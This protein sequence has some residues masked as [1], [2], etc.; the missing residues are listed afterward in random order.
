MRRWFATPLWQRILL[1]ILL[2]ALAGWLLGERAAQIKWIGDLFIRLIR[3]MVVPLVLAMI[4]TGVAALGDPRRLGT[5]GG[6]TIGLLIAMTALAVCVGL[7]LGTWLQP[8]AGVQLGAV[9]AGTPAVARPIAEQLLAIVPVNPFAAIA[10][11][12]MFSIIF[13]AMAISDLF[14]VHAVMPARMHCFILSLSSQHSLPS[15]FPVSLLHWPFALM[16]HMRSPRHF[17]IASRWAS[18]IR[19]FL[20]A[21]AEGLAGVLAAC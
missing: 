12:G 8:G 14:S 7:G 11:G 5:M 16:V 9:G 10:G 20:F 3:M 15:G 2:G 1:A 4:I 21:P 18:V 6:R 17:F 13:F 19:H